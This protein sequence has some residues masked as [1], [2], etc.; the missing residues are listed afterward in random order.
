MSIKKIGKSDSSLRSRACHSCFI[1]ISRTPHVT[2]GKYFCE[3]RFLLWTL[4][5][6]LHTCH[7]FRIAQ[8]LLWATSFFPSSAHLWSRVCKLCVSE[9]EYQCVWSGLD[10][11]VICG[12][13]RRRPPGSPKHLQREVTGTFE[14][15]HSVWEA[16][17]EWQPRRTLIL[18]STLLDL[19]KDNIANNLME[20]SIKGLQGTSTDWA[21]PT[22][23][24]CLGPAVWLCLKWSRQHLDKVIPPIKLG[25][26]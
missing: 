12:W 25:S 24:D 21:Q 5:C 7:H 10:L 26:W 1:D 11:D 13:D 17:G 18:F 14:K 2:E 3:S 16:T 15:G 4:L 8:R 23:S 9:P 19:R 22:N 20:L 6:H